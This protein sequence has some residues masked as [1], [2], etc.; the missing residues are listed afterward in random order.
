MVGSA[1]RRSL[2]RAPP[3]SGDNILA[4]CGKFLSEN[5]A[6][7]IQVTYEGPSSGPSTGKHRQ[8]YPAEHL[9]MRTGRPASVGRPEME[10]THRHGRSGRSRRHAAI[11]RA[12]HGS[13]GSFEAS[14]T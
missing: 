4:S 10:T 1:G 11:E 5:P 12:G 3:E 13:A 14:R 8:S 7:P 2:V 6:P 9:R